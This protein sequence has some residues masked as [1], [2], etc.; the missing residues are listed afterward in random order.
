MFYENRRVSFWIILF[1]A[2][3][4]NVIIFGKRSQILVIQCLCVDCN[5]SKQHKI[6]YGGCTHV[7]LLCFIKIGQLI[8]GYHSSFSKRS[9]LRTCVFAHNGLIDPASR[10]V[11]Q[12]FPKVNLLVYCILSTYPL[13]FEQS[14]S[15]TYSPI[16]RKNSGY[17]DSIQYTRRLYFGNDRST[18]L[19]EESIKR[20]AQT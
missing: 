8:L 15:K 13:C 5:H 17:V 12:S 2:K 11:D 14:Y 7:H 20:Y 9:K 10:S 1:E 19:E 6:L 4:G 3:N 18:D 16:F